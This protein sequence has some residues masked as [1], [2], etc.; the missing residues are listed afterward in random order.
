MKTNN[1]HIT[2]VGVFDFIVVGGGAAGC[3]LA[4]RLSENPNWKVLLLEAGPRDWNPFI[5]MPGGFYK[6]A[7]GALTWGFETTP[8]TSCNNRRISL[9]QG[10]VLGGGSS[11]NAQVYIRGHASDY[12]RWETEHGCTTWAYENVI[13]YFKKSERNDTFSDTFHGTTGELGV[14]SGNPIQISKRFVQACQE[15]GLTFN[16]DFNGVE[17]IGAGFYQTTTWN[18]V[19]SSTARAFLKGA[20]S[21]DNLTIKTNAIC[22]EI[23]IFE[24]KAQSV[25]Y[26]QNGRM[27]QADTTKEILV[28]AGAL[29]SPKL[30]M[31]SGI[32]PGEHLRSLDIKVKIANNLVGQNLQDHVNV[33]VVY[34]L[35]TDASYDKYKKLKYKMLAGLQ[36]LLFRQGP[37]ASN[38]V[39]A[40]AF[41]ASDNSG[42]VPDV[43]IHF[44]AGAGVEEGIGNV[45]VGAGV[46]MNCYYLRPKSRGSVRLGSANPSDPILVD[47]AFFQEPKDLSATC[48][49]VELMT[50]VM[51]QNS[52]ASEVEGM[53]STLGDADNQSDLEDYC[54]SNGRTGYHPVGT[55][56][57][58][59]SATNSVVDPELRVH[60]IERLR[61]CDSSIMPSLVSG[62]T[63]APTIMI[64]EKAADVIRTYWN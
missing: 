29:N 21:R 57:M 59:T 60:G 3:V 9:A 15:A 13:E 42:S 28:C 32:G 24:G 14:S 19:R 52:L 55:C 64:A 63:N 18:G 27:Y 10:R 45:N 23:Q 37:A 5:H 7:R 40:G 48:R 49:G 22:H 47:P 53:V 62:N 35:K 33:D 41:W 30:L 4:A 51:S 34:Q 11:I 39:E 6:V 50:N 46:T 56:K 61:V 1:A 25:Q 16:P 43:Q 26:E 12:D 31:L 44:L 36:Y 2:S 17:Q 54:R 38:I 20:R 8:Q 58:G